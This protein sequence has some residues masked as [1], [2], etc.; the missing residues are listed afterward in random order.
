MPHF[1]TTFCEDYLDVDESNG[2]FM[3]SCYYGGQLIYRLMII[4]LIG[5]GKGGSWIQP[6]MTLCSAFVCGAVMSLIFVLLQQDVSMVYIIYSLSGIVSG[7][8]IPDLYS[9]SESVRPLSGMVSFV[10]I[11]GFS[12]GDAL[13]VFAIGELFDIVGPETLPVAVLIANIIGFAVAIAAVFL[14]SKYKLH[15]SEILGHYYNRA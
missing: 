12:G 14:F 1:I 2:R 8:I 10:H 15:R 7:G 3:I 9:W 13:S 5:T 6:N 4:I 11:I